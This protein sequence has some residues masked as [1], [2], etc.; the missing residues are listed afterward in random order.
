HV[1]AFPRPLGDAGRLVRRVGSGADHRDRALGVVLANALRR[2][3]TGH[4]G[5]D[6]QIFGRVH[7]SPL[8]GDGIQLEQRAEALVLL[9]AR[10][11]ADEVG[12]QARAEL[13]G[14]SACELELDVAVELRET[15]VAA[16]L[17]L[18]TAEQALESR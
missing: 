16:D 8:S 14:G 11:T 6:D 10:G 3:V 13:V 9:R 2:H 12:A 18:V 7:L 1:S 15:L 4:P 5:A 17:R